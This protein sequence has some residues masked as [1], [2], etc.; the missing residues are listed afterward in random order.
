VSLPLSLGLS[1]LRLLIQRGWGGGAKSVCF[2][3][4]Y[5]TWQ[6]QGLKAE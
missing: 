2:A 4:T 6:W 3:L 5:S 1:S